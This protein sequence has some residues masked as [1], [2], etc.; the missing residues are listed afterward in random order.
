[1][2]EV[3]EEHDG[4]VFINAKSLDTKSPA[5]PTSEL[6]FVL[7]LLGKSTLPSPSAALCYEPSH[8]IRSEWPCVRSL[9]SPTSYIDRDL[10]E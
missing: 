3:I 8:G 6:P 1:M 9:A 2:H 10:N 7:N 4:R 5:A